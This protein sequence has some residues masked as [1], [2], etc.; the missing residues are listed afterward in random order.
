M[1]V[2]LKLMRGMPVKHGRKL[3]KLQRLMDKSTD[4]PQWCEAAQEHD[5]LTGKKRWRDVDQT[6]EYDY[7]QIR[8]RLD[9]LRSLRARH[10]YH[11]LLFSLNEGIHGNMGG[12]GRSALYQHANFGTKRLI[13]Q[14]IDEIDDSLR[15]LAELD[16]SEID[17]QEKLDFFSQK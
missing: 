14:Y 11:G 12:M 4:Y 8:L 3:K 13:E 9:K 2:W 16:S 7:V 10:D 6:T 1:T 5:E 17:P 15:F